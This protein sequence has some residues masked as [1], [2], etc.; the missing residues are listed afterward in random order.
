[1]KRLFLIYLSL[2]I[3]F[4]VVSNFYLP[5]STAVKTAN[6]VGNGYLR[7]ITDDTPFYKYPNDENC[8]FYLPYTYYVKVL[9][10]DGEMTHVECYGQSTAA[11]DGYVP[12]HLLFDDDLSVS[13][14]F[15]DITLTTC[16]SAVLYADSR[17][18]KPIQYLFSERQ[19]YYYGA[20]STDNARLY[21][22][23]YN[24]RLGYV[25]EEDVYPFE[26]Q[27]HPN[28]LTFIKDE[29][30]EENPLPDTSETP[31]T[32]QN[33]ADE[34]FSLKVIIIVCLL[35]AGIVALF[36]ALKQ[37]PLHRETAGGYYDE[38]EYE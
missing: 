16:T 36:V 19:M 2:I 7:V 27:N 21:F 15:A 20:F 4:T 37:K 13:S 10:E 32:Q 18:T 29:Q 25:K 5:L 3:C 9:G 6:A 38:N 17:L 23:S 11:I 12:T 1:M 14:P 22:V 24:G 26:I 8:L 34:F 33:I 31:S 35:F 30:V 28:E